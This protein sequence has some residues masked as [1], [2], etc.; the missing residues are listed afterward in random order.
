MARTGGCGSGPAGCSRPADERRAGRCWP[1]RR[2]SA[3]PGSD[4]KPPASSAALMP[5]R[6]LANG[7]RGSA[8]RP[9][10]ATPISVSSRTRSPSRAA[11]QAGDLATEGE[12]GHAA[13]ACRSEKLGSSRRRRRRRCSPAPTASAAW[14]SRRGPECRPPTARSAGTAPEWCG[15]NA[16]MSPSRHGTARAARR[17]PTRA[18]PWS[19]HRTAS[20]PCARLRARASTAAA[21]SAP[22][23]WSGISIVERWLV[24]SWIVLIWEGSGWETASL[25]WHE[26]SPPSARAPAWQ[27]FALLLPRLLCL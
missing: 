18:T 4:G 24:H 13:D 17:R 27:G 21:G 25:P 26:P 3:P 8:R 11:D 12:A 1:G 10:A 6:R 14:P 9:S 20:S 7:S 19:R 15:S 23:T 5:G 16:S 2:S 22:A